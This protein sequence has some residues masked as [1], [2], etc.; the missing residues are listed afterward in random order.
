MESDR[1][2]LVQ[3]DSCNITELESRQQ[4]FRELEGRMINKPGKMA[5][6]VYR[7]FVYLRIS[8]YARKE[9]RNMPGSSVDAIESDLHLVLHQ[10]AENVTSNLKLEFYYIRLTGRHRHSQWNLQAHGRYCG[11]SGRHGHVHRIQHR[12]HVGASI[13]GHWA[14]P[15][16]RDLQG[17]ICVYRSSRNMKLHH[18]TG[19][20]SP[21]DGRQAL[22]IN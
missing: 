13:R 2:E 17:E 11:G 10:R 1:Q 20:F 4:Q 22:E 16:S 9:M 18:E 21:M 19:V 5:L 3:D 12:E 6:A 8:K 15:T 7:S 14:T